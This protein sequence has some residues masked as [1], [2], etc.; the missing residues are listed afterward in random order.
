MVAK[1]VAKTAAKAVR[2]VLISAVK[3]ADREAKVNTE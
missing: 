1:M 3:A 2:V